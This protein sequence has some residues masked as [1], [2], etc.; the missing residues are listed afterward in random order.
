MLSNELQVGKAAEHLVV[1]DLILAGY[2]AFLTDA[3]LPFDVCVVLG[4]RLVRIQVKATQKVMERRNSAVV[5][6]HHY[7]DIYRFGLRSAKRG[8]RKISADN[9]DVFAMVALDQR[10]IAYLK[11]T[12]LIVDEGLN[13]VM[14]AVEFKSRSL[15][16]PGRTYSN[17]TVRSPYG[18]FLEDYKD[19]A[20]AL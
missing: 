2:N 15:E 6:R 1:A 20:D 4:N 10:K 18:R 14:S 3:G 7:Q 17:G 9:V 13:T 19:F 16:Y 11:A 8:A 12:T 5:E